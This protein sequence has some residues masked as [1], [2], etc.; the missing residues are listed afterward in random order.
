MRLIGSRAIAVRPGGL[1]DRQ[2]TVA[3]AGMKREVLGR[4]AL[5]M[6]DVSCSQLSLPR[7]APKPFCYTSWTTAPLR[8]GVVI[9][10]FHQTANCV[11]A[12]LRRGAHALLRLE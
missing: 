7:H 4:S 2:A 3:V 6:D 12:L 8:R 11:A 10:V 1:V 9:T 5:P